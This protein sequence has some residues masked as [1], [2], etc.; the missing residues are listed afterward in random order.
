MFF[1]ERTFQTVLNGVSGAL[2]P[3]GAITG[4][5]NAVLLLCALFAVYEAY[6]R[7]GDA[8]MI[9]IAAAKFLLLGLVLANYDTIFRSVNGT[10]NQV[11]VAISPNDWASNWMLQVNQYFTGLGN[12][13]WF[14]LVVS[15]IVALI[16]VLVQLIAAVVFPIALL[17]FTILYCLYGAVL[18]ACGPLIL[19][20]YP[21]FGVGQ[22]ARSY[23]V[24]LFIFH[25]WGIVYALFSVL[26]TAVNA[27]SLA[28]MLSADS[29]GGWFQGASTALL[30]SL[31]SILFAVMVA[32][33]P[34]LARRIVTG[35]IGSS[36]LAI[37]YTVNSALG[38]VKSLAMKKG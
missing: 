32:L 38:S 22:L 13:S 14:N 8:R 19:A 31:A 21:A 34:F 23:L 17:I 37:I 16:S 11:A 5:A 7:G 36:M 30:M 4:I 28:A 6:A 15:S 18:Y 29:L 2:G 24:N 27:D 33:I 26:L 35:E 1:F 9:G 12:A 10:F 25:A 20:L 3:M